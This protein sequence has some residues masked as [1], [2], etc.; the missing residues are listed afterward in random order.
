NTIIKCIAALVISFSLNYVLTTWAAPGYPGTA[1]ATG[2]LV[3]S[4]GFIFAKFAMEIV[5]LPM[6]V[7]SL[8]LRLVSGKKI[9]ASASAKK[10]KIEFFGRALFVLIF[11]FISAITGIY[12]GALEGG[13]GWFVTSVL[14]GTLGIFLAILMP[15][16]LIWAV[17]G[18]D[19]LSAEPTAAG[20][21]DIEQARKDGNR[22]VLFADKVARKLIDAII[23]KPDTKN[24]P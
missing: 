13:M 8:V 4:F 3:T 7:I 16:E 17:E 6:A 20:K 5:M 15:E 14:F 12:I 11:C 21:A 1:L 18:G 10:D 23:E 19:S 22:S 24:K 2:V 9:I